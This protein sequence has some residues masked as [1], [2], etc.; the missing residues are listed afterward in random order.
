MPPMAMTVLIVAHGHPEMSRGGAE[1]ASHALFRALREMPGVTSYYLARTG[2]PAERRQGRPLS[3]FRGRPD[4]LL[5][6]S[7]G[8]DPFRFSQPSG[9]VVDHFARLVGRLRPNVVHFHHYAELGLELIEAV[10]R[11][12]PRAGIVLTLHEFLAICHHHGV[13]VK[14]GEAFALCDG[15]SPSACGACF[16]KIGGAAFADRERTIRAGFAGVDRFVAPSEFLRRRYIEWGIAADRIVTLEN[17]IAPPSAPPPRPLAAGGCRCVFGFFGQLHPFKGL[18]P[19]LEAFALL[20]EWP[21]ADAAGIRLVVHG[22]YLELNAPPY[23]ERVAAL[24]ARTAPRVAFAGPYEPA[25]LPGLMAVVD[26]VVV[27][28]IWWE[29]SPLVIEEALAHRRPVVC[30]GIGG[31]AEKVRNGLDGFH[32]PVADPA[33]LAAL[34]VRCAADPAAWDRL[35]RT[36]RRPLTVAEAAARHLDLYREVKRNP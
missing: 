12:A 25:A 23:V 24:L 27:P 20:D 9:E 19:L 16:P 10:R 36:M 18:L 31:M 1:I 21:Q 6:F 15:S 11:A 35:Q 17:G 34:I 32:A 7:E 2:D 29:N 3:V 14:T 26:W 8:V 30:G 13:M 5:L 22:A 33:A 4:E 28:S